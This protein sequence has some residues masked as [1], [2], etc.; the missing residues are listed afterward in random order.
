MSTFCCNFVWL[1]SNR[2]FFSIFTI[3]EGI[4][5]HSISLCKKQKEATGNSQNSLLK[6]E[7]EAS[8]GMTD[9]SPDQHHDYGKQIPLN[10]KTL[11]LWSSCSIA[12]T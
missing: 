11:I 9:M 2:S 8:S 5:D 4:H 1:L 7:S 12:Q 10:C 6:D 3:L